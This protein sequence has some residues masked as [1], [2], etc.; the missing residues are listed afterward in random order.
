MSS[1]EPLQTL[2]FEECLDTVELEFSAKLEQVHLAAAGFEQEALQF[3]DSVFCRERE[4]HLHE[5]KYK[6]APLLVHAKQV[7]I[8]FDVCS[9]HF[10][11]KIFDICSMYFLV[12][13][14]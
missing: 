13:I 5:F 12:K 14:L 8:F 7:E 3:P 9:T 10:L 11:V 2:S 1:K 6:L 4:L